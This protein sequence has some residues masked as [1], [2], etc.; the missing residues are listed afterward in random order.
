[1]RLQPGGRSD[2]ASQIALQSFST[3]ST[4]V[5]AEAVQNKT[6][7]TIP[8]KEKKEITTPQLGPV[9]GRIVAEVFLGLLFA[10]RHGSYLASDPHWA[11]PS[12]KGYALKNFVE[13]ALG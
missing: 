3:E 5:L 9:G 6:T 13:F 2:I 10:D 11:P 7:V 1:M 4:Y 12:G 8:V